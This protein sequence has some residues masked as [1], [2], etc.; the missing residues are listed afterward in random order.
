M[1]GRLVPNLKKK[2][3]ITIYRSNHIPF[4]MNVF[5]INNNYVTHR[6]DAK[7]YNSNRNL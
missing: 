3:I 1:K 4:I 6:L 5:I 7:L 2:N